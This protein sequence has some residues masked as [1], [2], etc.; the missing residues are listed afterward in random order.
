MQYPHFSTRIQPGPERPRTTKAD[1]ETS[2]LLNLLHPNPRS[3]LYNGTKTAER[4]RPENDH[5]VA[6]ATIEVK[7]LNNE[8]SGNAMTRTGDT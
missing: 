7:L 5:A 1:V 3:Q 6:L 2:P 4:Q 8:Y